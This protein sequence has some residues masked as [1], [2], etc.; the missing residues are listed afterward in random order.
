MR[1]QHRDREEHEQLDAATQRLLRAHRRGVEL[2][3]RRGISFDR[4]LDAAEH[5]FQE[6]GLR[7]RVAAPQSA[8]QRGDDEQREAE[9]ADE[10]E[11]EPEVLRVEGL[12]EQVE[13]AMLDIDQDRRLA[14]DLDPR[15]R[16][17]ERDQQVPE[18]V[19]SILELAAAVRG[20][21][22]VA[23]PVRI[24]AH[25]RVEVR[26]PRAPS[27]LLDRWPRDPRGLGCR[28]GQSVVWVR[29]HAVLIQRRAARALSRAASAPHFAGVLCFAVS[30]GGLP[31]RF[32]PRSD[33]T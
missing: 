21:D 8:P 5:A 23:R 30:S 2:G 15:H 4:A 22:R 7:T 25:Q 27:A 6:H 11:R 17:V 33:S 16:E 1:D 9:P 12:T 10:E 14:A 29:V 3:A 18:P 32:L 28:S 20:M 26:P 31:F 24:D 13:V 19:L